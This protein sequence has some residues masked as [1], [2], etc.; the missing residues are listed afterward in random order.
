[1]P[2]HQLALQKL[3]TIDRVEVSEEGWVK[4]IETMIPHAK[5]ILM[6]DVAAHLHH[7]G[8]V[9]HRLPYVEYVFRCPYIQHDVVVERL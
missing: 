6:D 8:H 4:A 3:K 5:W 1:M 9:L 2:V 7:P